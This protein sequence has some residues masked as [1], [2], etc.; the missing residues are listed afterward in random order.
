MK[1][2]NTLDYLRGLTAFSIMIYHLILF[3]L[4]LINLTFL[5]QETKRRRRDT[6]N[7]SENQKKG[8]RKNKEEPRRK[9]NEGEPQTRTS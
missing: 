6:G 3:S 5:T 9:A 8:K 2:I 7:S 1:R 4:H